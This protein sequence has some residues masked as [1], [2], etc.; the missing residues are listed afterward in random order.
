MARP[1]LDRTTEVQA[2][3]GCFTCGDTVDKPRWTAKNAMAVAATH[4]RHR[5]HATWCEQHLEV[6][7]GKAGTE[8]DI[9]L[10]G[11]HV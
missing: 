9:P 2:V 11:L 4:A 6:R 8:F 1:R 3:A 7:Y 10:P 5:G